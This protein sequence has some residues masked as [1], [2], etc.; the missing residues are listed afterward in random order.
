VISVII[1]QTV[2][3]KPFMADRFNSVLKGVYSKVR[4]CTVR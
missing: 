2:D 3:V 1:C 4:P